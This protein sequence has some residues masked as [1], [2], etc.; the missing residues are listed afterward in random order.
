M[1][2]VFTMIIEGKLP[3]HFVWRDARCVAFLSI[4]PINP[5][6]VL[7]VPIEEVG[8]WIDLDADLLLHVT[9]V[10]QTIG[11]ALQAVYSPVKVGSMYA[12][13]EVEHVHQH[14]VPIYEI[15]DL[16]FANADT[17]ATAEQIAAEA[18]KI[19]EALRE[20][21]AEHVAG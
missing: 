16:N 5:G 9:S 2:S 21:G 6:H 14:L 20:V 1:A 3:G 17:S 7:V 8:H 11:K 13:F 10:A 18:E 15:A 19:R 12:G 4:H